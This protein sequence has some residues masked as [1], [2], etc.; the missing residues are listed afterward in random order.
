MSLANEV[1][2]KRFSEV[3]GQGPVSGN[4]LEQMKRAKRGTIRQSWMFHGDNGSGKT[5]I[6][7][8]MAVSFQLPLEKFGEPTDA[9]YDSVWSPTGQSLNPDIHN[10]NASLI[11][12]KEE[13]A[14][15]IDQASYHPAVAKYKV[16]ILDE[17][18]KMTDA[19]QNLLLKALEEPSPK[20]IWIICT[21][22]PWKILKGI[23]Q[24][25]LAYRMCPLDEDAVSMLVDRAA[26]KAGITKPTAKLKKS[27]GDKLVTSGRAVVNAV[28][29]F[30]GGAS[31]KSSTKGA[32]EPEVD[33]LAVCR[34]AIAGD[35][36]GVA[37]SMKGAGAEDARLVRM[38]VLGYL[39]SVLI[40]NPGVRVAAAIEEMAV[41][42]PYE[43]PAALALIYA[44]LYRV[45]RIFKGAA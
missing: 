21:T 30:G 16:F 35:W 32:D 33:G 44:K 15:L 3:I 14:A 1:R 6:A 7:K 18:H 19:A 22:M 2:P 24:R 39:K 43:D 37:R 40:Q 20:A 28:E 45:C 9:E 31:S 5:T 26:K 29:Q 12:T 36:A 11:N 23:K 38:A 10:V 27:L 13:I 34:N 42:L 8:I 17:A 4:I 25:C 41:L